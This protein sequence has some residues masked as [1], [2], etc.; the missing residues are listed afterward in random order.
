MATID[1]KKLHQNAQGD[2]Q[3]RVGVNRLWLCTVADMLDRLS[4][5]RDEPYDTSVI[6]MI[7]KTGAPDEKAIVTRGW[8]RML[9]TELTNLQQRERERVSRPTH[10]ENHFGPRVHRTV[11]VNGHE[12]PAHEFDEANGHFTKMFEHMNLG[13]SKLFGKRGLFE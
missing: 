6:R 1:L 5:F 12:V 9:H 2:P 8:L 3:A 7:A 11:I 10:T 13:F 4:V